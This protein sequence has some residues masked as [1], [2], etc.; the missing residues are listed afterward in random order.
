[1]SNEYIDIRPENQLL[2]TCIRA[3]TA[4]E[5]SSDLIG[6]LQLPLDWNYFMGK[7]K[8]HCV[9]PLV[10][11][12]LNRIDHKVIPIEVLHYLRTSARQIT[13][14]NLSMVGEL[15][16]IVVVLEQHNIP[17]MPF[18]GPALAM[19]AYG[20]LSLRQFA[21]LDILIQQKDFP[22]ARALLIER[23]YHPKHNLTTPE[24]I[25]AYP[26]KVHH[27][28]RLFRPDGLLV[29]LE[30]QVMQRPFAFPPKAK[31]WWNNLEQLPLGG[32]KIRA[33]PL[34]KLLL[35]LC[36][37]GSKHLWDRLI[38]ICD[39]AEIIR[40][41]PQIDWKRLFDEARNLGAE[42]MLC[43]GLYMA[44]NL[45]NAPIPE[46]VLQ[47]ITKD[48]KLPRL[49]ELAVQLLFREG[50]ISNEVKEKTHLYRFWMMGRLR[51]RVRISLQ[52]A[53]SL[54]DPIRLYRTYGLAPI[55]HL[56]GI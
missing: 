16:Q 43:F 15:L 31:E 44:H 41:N 11:Q 49:V 4:P 40:N 18:K 29:E 55:K 48:R 32:Q 46:D 56:L 23:G 54:L 38:W 30:W 14:H 5:T 2:L 10:Y 12:C 1:M 22:T 21:D 45:L 36:V 35:I 26:Y 19:Q 3:V 7:A 50:D 25:A 20:N 9:L 39:I 47:R 17:A 27:E 51:D 28:Y 24:E 6:L 34:E 13:Q 53:P 52:H 42:R 8:R 37:H 33:L